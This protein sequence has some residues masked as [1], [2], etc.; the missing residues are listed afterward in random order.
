MDERRPLFGLKG[1]E[2]TVV[3]IVC[4]VAGIGTTIGLVIWAANT[5]MGG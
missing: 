1:G 5:V 3:A 4:G 2:L